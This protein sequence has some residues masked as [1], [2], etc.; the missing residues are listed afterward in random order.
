[1]VRGEIT[2][3]DAAMRANDPDQIRRELAA[4]VSA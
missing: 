2:R 3:E 4:M 1:V